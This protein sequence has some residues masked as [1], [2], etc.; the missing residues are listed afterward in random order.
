MNNEKFIEI[1]KLK[2]EIENLSLNIIKLN[3]ENVIYIDSINILNSNNKILQIKYDN[4]IEKVTS[5]NLENNLNI[6]RIN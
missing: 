4:L 3:D 5:V 2:E 1:S 6:N